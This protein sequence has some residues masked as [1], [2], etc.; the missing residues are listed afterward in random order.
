[1]MAQAAAAQ[2][3]ALIAQMQ[4]K[5]A[6]AMQQAIQSGKVAAGAGGY[7]VGMARTVDARVYEQVGAGLCW[8]WPHIGALCSMQ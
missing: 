2:K 4:Q 3:M 1:M 8:R 6:E 5:S 7:P